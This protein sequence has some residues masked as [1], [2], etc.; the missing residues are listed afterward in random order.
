MIRFFDNDFHL[1]KIILATQVPPSCGRAVHTDR[2]SHGLV[3]NTGEDKA[4]HFSNGVTLV[5]KHDD[6]LYLPKHSNYRVESLAAS[7]GCHAINF[8][9]DNDEIYEPFT[10]QVLNPSLFQSLFEKASNAWRIKK[11]GCEIK[12][13][14]V[15]YEIIYQIKNQLHA[16]YI[17][18][19]GLSVI[20]PAVDYIGNNYG[21]PDITAGELADLCGI[22]EVYLRL[23]FT[24]RFGMP[25]VKYLN[26]VR[27]AR[28]K[29]LL[30]TGAYTVGEVAKHA[31]F[32]DHAYFSRE[33][34]K[35]T[36]LSPSGFAKHSKL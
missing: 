32:A 22:S 15:F 19:S 35:A 7:E 18:K 26:I 21:K 34:R 5:L 12:V 31:G 27:I 25:P 2:Q 24:K 11:V 4:Y 36:N 30:I 33:F 6:I 17:S 23:L 1:E 8:I 9:T 10:M 13:F 20:D 16:E 14:S 28:A 29:E 3:F